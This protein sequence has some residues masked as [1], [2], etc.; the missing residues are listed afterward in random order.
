MPDRDLRLGIR[1]TA[2]GKGLRGEI[3][4]SRRELDRFT[5][6]EERGAAAGRRYSRRQ[7]QAARATR[8][9]GRSALEAHGRLGR[10]L[11]LFAGGDL[12]RRGIQQ[13]VELSDANVELGNRLRLVTDSE[14]ES[15][16][17][18]DRLVDISQ[19]TRTELSAN[20]ALYSRLSLAASDLG[21]DED[22]L[23][24]VTDLLNKQLKIGGSNAREGAQGLIQFAQGIASGRLQG[25]ELRSV[26]EN[27]L[28]VQQGLIVGFA[29]LR[30]RGEID[31]EVTRAN[32]RDLASQGVLS[33]ELLLD[34]ILASADDTERKWQDVSHGIGSA[35]VQVRNSVQLLVADFEEETGNFEGIARGIEGVSDA[36][37]NVD[38][39]SLERVLRVGGLLAAL[40]GGRLA[41]G[42][43]LYTRRQIG[44]ALANQ[45]F[46]STALAAHARA[47]VL[48]VGL[49]H[50]AR[51]AVAYGTALRGLAIASNVLF[52]PVGLIALGV[53]SVY[54]LTRG[55]RELEDSA[56]TLAPAFN[57]WGDEIGRTR[58]EL[59]KL[60]EA[61]RDVV[62]LNLEEEIDRAQSRLAEARRELAREEAGRIAPLGRER[63]VRL[64]ADDEAITRAQANVDTLEQELEQLQ[65]R[66][67]N[68]AVALA[69]VAR[70]ADA[71]VD[72][73]SRYIATLNDE[74][75]EAFEKA[76]EQ[77]A[78]R[79]LSIDRALA[80]ER[81]RVEL[82]YQQRV[83][84]IQ[85]QFSGEEA[86]RRLVRAAELRDEDLAEITRREREEQAKAAAAD[87]ERAAAAAA[88]AT[89]L[90][91][92]RNENA[93]I[94]AGGAAALAQIE[95][96]RE[97][98]ELILEVIREH[99]EVAPD[100]VADL[101][102]ER[103]AREELTEVMELQAAV[104]ARILALAVKGV[105][106]LPDLPGGKET[107]TRK[108]NLQDYAAVVGDLE[109]TLSR[110]ASGE[111]DRS[112]KLFRLRQAA[113]YG[114]A[115]VN[116]AAGVSRA[117]GEFTPPAN[118]VFAGIVAAIGAAQ[119]AAIRSAP[120][121][122]GFRYGGVIDRRVDFSYGGG[123]RGFAG[124]A[125]AEAILPLSRTPS[126]ELGVRGTAGGHTTL[127]LDVGGL[128]IT[129]Q[130][131]EGTQD[132]EGFGR[133][134][135]YEARRQ[136]EPMV[137]DIM[138]EQQ[139]P[140]GISNPTTT[141]T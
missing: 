8:E 86:S 82:D 33:S 90:E 57:R 63:F 56:V 105:R 131:P 136:L 35:L 61:Q 134:A 130:A 3:R 99:A 88:A 102:A 27:L 107:E 23:L 80:T 66:A 28:G 20:A 55:Q 77:L 32:I 40:Y 96:E 116:T 31:F 126:G 117:L 9:V 62:R 112:R 132:P 19:D 50:G 72:P 4:L 46:S 22:E 123:R 54:E 97:Q 44:A 113:A 93:R 128:S 30:R 52:G 101:V 67:G 83:K 119:I 24:R 139:R 106:P 26:M 133:I 7:R 79:R 135:A 122:Q 103:L 70:S 15:A 16:R 14:E 71:A 38:P 42:L 2:D 137:I 114:S 11:G 37:D 98:R 95:R 73:I 10:Y 45:T 17:V 25:D 69:D 43:V 48:T 141:V 138:R 51:A 74:D 111:G 89:E 36:I 47:S 1:L 84:D 115:I 129:V 75:R 49:S 21:R 109:S 104:S 85:E 140:G 60:T 39:E 108:A 127:V 5:R 91:R 65:D 34:A 59:E 125:G 53:Y 121:P 110:F 124:E 81:E 92:L 94:A 41:V 68:V 18:R 6:S 12:I 100:V 58:E 118:L 64:E 87:R 13:T 78:R 120:E 29:E 76:Q